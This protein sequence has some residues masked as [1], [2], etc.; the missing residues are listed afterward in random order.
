MASF[1]SQIPSKFLED[2]EIAEWARDLTLF[3]ND[4]VSPEG[5]IATSEATTVVVLTQQEKL[6]L[7]TVTQDV[8][9]D[10]I[11]ADTASNKAKIDLIATSSLTYSISND[12]TDRTF[13]ADAAVA[14][15]GIDVADAGPTNV[16]LLSDHDALVTVV[17]EQGDVQATV[18]RDLVAKGILGV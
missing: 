10:T 8:N 15:T 4:L 11:E 5:V 7:M 14:G 12:G 1:T 17:L 2:P 3:I 6:N 18:I 13:N 9:L 16:A